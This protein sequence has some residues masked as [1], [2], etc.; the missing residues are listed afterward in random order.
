MKFLFT[1][2]GEG[3]GHFTQALSMAAMLRKHGHEVVAV[4]VGKSKA[5]EVPSFFTE[6]IDAP[7]FDF[8]SPNFTSLYK[9][10]K[11]SI[12]LSSIENFVQTSYYLKSMQFVKEKI[13]EFRP[14]TVINF[15]DLIAGLTFSFY[16]LDEKLKIEFVC[17]GHQYVL[18]NPNFKTSAEQDVRYYFLRGLTKWTC[19]R[20]SKILALSFRY[21][22]D[23]E[24]RC[25]YNVP[26]LLRPEVFDIAPQ[27]GDYI[28]GYML[29]PGYFSDI[30]AWHRDNPHVPLQ[31]FW[32]KK[33]TEELTKIDDNLILHQLND[34]KFLHSMARCKAYSTTSGFESVCEAM[35]FGKPILMIPVHVEQE[36]NA[37]DA[38]LSGAGVSNK[39]FDLD[40]LIEFIPHY[41]PDPTFKTWVDSA[42]K[43]IVS[44]LCKKKSKNRIGMEI[45]LNP[46]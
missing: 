44:V 6:K 20:A 35:Y 7:V 21:L 5:R 3:R 41:N 19:Q 17:I 2:Q 8:K 25:I 23:N 40:K 11:P 34:H 28:H 10:K 43:R 27:K 36:F 15:Y 13:E 30:K 39:K 16:K 46:K 22:P 42:E 18:L 32:D 38:S 37:Y 26:P 29:N 9:D 1:V 4:L 12:V 31:F 45:F 14:D 24:D 33:D